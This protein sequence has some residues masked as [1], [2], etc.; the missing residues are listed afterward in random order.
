VTRTPGQRFRKPLLYPP[1]LRGR[2]GSN[3]S[4]LQSIAPS[5]SRIR[6][7]VSAWIGPGFGPFHNRAFLVRQPTARRSDRDAPPILRLAPTTSATH[8]ALHWLMVESASARD[9]PLRVPPLAGDLPS[10]L[11]NA[12][13]RR[14]RRAIACVRESAPAVA[15][16]APVPLDARGGHRGDDWC[17]RDSVRVRQAPGLSFDPCS[18][19]SRGV[20]ARTVGK[21][22]GERRRANADRRHGPGLHAEPAELSGAAKEW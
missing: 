7:E 16:P 11:S 6:P 2:H 14:A 19:V 21:R 13:A 22:Y 20:S 10:G 18:P 1:E 8:D 4:S 5:I 9:H 3:S 15:R 17:C 12:H